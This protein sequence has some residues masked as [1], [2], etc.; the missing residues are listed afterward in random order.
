MKKR[1]FILGS[2]GL[3]GRNLCLYL[4]DSH[5]VIG[6]IN[7]RSFYLNGVKKV[8]FNLFNKNKLS[9]FINK[10]KPSIVINATGI[11]NVEECENNK[12]KLLK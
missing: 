9:E 5:D 11:T 7:K 2:S 12:K 8:N 6:H 3:L 1:V 10:Y 4:K